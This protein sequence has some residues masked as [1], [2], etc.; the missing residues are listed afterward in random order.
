MRLAIRPR[1][2]ATFTYLQVVPDRLQSQFAEATILADK[3]R[4]SKLCHSCVVKNLPE[5][6]D[7]TLAEPYNFLGEAACDA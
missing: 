1:R 3:V 5:L 7:A 4:F 6:L 2:R